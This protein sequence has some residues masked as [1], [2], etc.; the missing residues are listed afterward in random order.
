MA[1]S[2]YRINKGINKPVEFKGLK[3]QYIVYLAIGLIALLIV[4][5]LL[6]IAGIKMFFCLVLIVVLGVLLFM[7]VY[8]MSDM[9][10]QHGLLKKMAK[11]NIP[12]YLKTGSRKSF[13]QLKSIPHGKL[14]SIR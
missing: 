8:R 1:S 5:A 14:N 9:Y 13:L 10:G 4:F 7:A 12:G 11:R 3:A 2:V 6:Y